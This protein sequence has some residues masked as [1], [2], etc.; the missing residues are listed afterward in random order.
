V[1]V[2][3]YYFYPSVLSSVGL[4]HAYYW[5][6]EDPFLA[7]L[8]PND[9]FLPCS[10]LA[11]LYLGSRSSVVAVANPFQETLDLGE[12]LAVHYY[13]YYSVVHHRHALG[14]LGHEAVAAHQEPSFVW[15]EVRSGLLETVSSFSSDETRSKS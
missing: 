10:A 14:I 11:A 1:A 8:A 13:Y 5:D 12:V 4:V 9:L 2:P 7:Y 3:Y 6:V 15:Q